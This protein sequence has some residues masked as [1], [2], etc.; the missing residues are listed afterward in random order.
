MTVIESKIFFGDGV[1][2][3]EGNDLNEQ[4]ST[5]TRIHGFLQPRQCRQINR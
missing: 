3:E 5:T 4:H 1:F 2:I